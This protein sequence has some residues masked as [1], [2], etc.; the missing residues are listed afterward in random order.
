MAGDS[1]TG[2]DN[3]QHLM[4]EVSV[5]VSSC[6]WVHLMAQTFSP[7]RAR[8]ILILENNNIC[9]HL[10]LSWSVEILLKC[11]TLNS[12]NDGKSVLRTATNNHIY[13]MHMERRRSVCTIIADFCF[14]T[15]SDPLDHAMNLQGMVLVQIFPVLYM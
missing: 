2:V 13:W 9:V 14:R 8:G 15:I 4:N 3:S 6:V 5:I 12:S 1:Y 10:T 11:L 7:P